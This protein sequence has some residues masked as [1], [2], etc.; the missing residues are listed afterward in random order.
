MTELR[1]LVQQRLGYGRAE[2]IGTAEARNNR[3]LRTRIHTSEVR[4]MA[5]LRSLEQQRLGYGRAED[6]G[7]AEAIAKWQAVDTAWYRKG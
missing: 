6:I 7:T 1:S 2:D 3:K 4:D 5:E